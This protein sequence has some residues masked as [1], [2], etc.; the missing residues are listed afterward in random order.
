MK[1]VVAQCQL[2]HGLTKGAQRDWV[3]HHQSVGCAQTAADAALV[4]GKELV[5]KVALKVQGL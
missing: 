3:K 2:L 4:V 1:H 5:A